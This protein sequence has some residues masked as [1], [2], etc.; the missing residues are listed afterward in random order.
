MT[1][2]WPG[3]GG[4]TINYISEAPAPEALRGRRPIVI[5]GSTGSIGGNALKVIRAHAA[6]F[7]VLG[8]AC[9]R[10]VAALAAQAAEF[11]PPLLAVLDQ[12]AADA[13]R[14]R[15][16]DMR[17]AGYAPEI[18]VGAEGYARMA[19]LPEVRMVLSAQVGA[20]GLDGTLAAA[21]AG[22][23]IALANKESLVLAGDLLR[24]VCTARSSV[25]L[26]VDSEYSALF[27]CLAG[28][29]QDAQELILTASGGPF[30][31]RRRDELRHVTREQAL[32]H[33][34]W[35]MGA[36]ITID[37]ATMMNKAL[38]V[39]EAY[40]L[41][42]IPREALRVAVH[43]Q[44]VVHSLVRFRDG[45]LLAQM[46]PADMRLPIGHC[47][48]WPECLSVN[49]PGLDLFSCGPLEFY[50]P[51]PEAFPSVALAW[52]ALERR[53]GACVV[54]NAANEAAVE[55]FLEGRCGFTDIA[56]IIA[57]VM[58]RHET[59]NDSRRPWSLPDP[60]A[61]PETTAAH[62]CEAM[63]RIQNLDQKSRELA[64]KLARAG[65]SE[66]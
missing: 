16:R 39:V 17:P 19:S 27:Q 36:K 23:I 25:I 44:S 21:L 56:D 42:G 52:R 49:A 62:A 50:E 32:K 12:E 59:G 13:L 61:D 33:P 3:R 18:L 58:D 46:G 38:E 47:L 28:R 48:L 11:R 31:G 1:A 15:L 41:Y 29:G 5:L 6:R 45:G 20:A 43:P 63:T 8:L 64:R 57:E 4:P 55:L 60:A 53:G 2:L 34:N 9:A 14:Q 65:V 37:S 35:S 30:R 24:R 10:N 7:S 54:M 26:P 66:C 51:D 40:H 22:K